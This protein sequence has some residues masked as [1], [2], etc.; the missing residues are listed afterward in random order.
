MKKSKLLALVDDAHTNEVSGK[1]E[2]MTSQP[3][4]MDAEFAAFQVCLA[5]FHL[6]EYSLVI[7]NKTLY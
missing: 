6:Q 7:I 3:N 1:S 4:D 5:T 2:T